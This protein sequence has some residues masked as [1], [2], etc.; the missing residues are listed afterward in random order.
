M[1]RVVTLSCCEAITI[2]VTREGVEKMNEQKPGNVQDLTLADLKRAQRLIRKTH[3]DPIDP[4]LRFATPHGDYWLGI[5]LPDDLGQRAQSFTMINTLLVFKQC[6][7][8][9][10]A[11]EIHV[12]DAVI[13]IGMSHNERFMCLS[14]ITRA[15]LQFSDTA[16]L[17]AAQIDP[18]ILQLMPHAL[19]NV[20]GDDQRAL[21]G[22]FGSDGMFPIVHI[23]SGRVGLS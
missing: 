14:R 8:F 12:P 17:D 6:Q 13:C 9:T 5:T 19:Q 7:A 2:R 10:L 22:W 3:P 20:T 23:D 1:P 15:P 11:S 18:Q 21:Q 16:W 4:Q